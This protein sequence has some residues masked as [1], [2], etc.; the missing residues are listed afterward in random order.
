MQEQWQNW[1]KDQLL[2]EGALTGQE[3]VLWQMAEFEYD[4]RMERVNHS[5]KRFLLV[6]IQL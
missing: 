5:E 1:L 6:M 3:L 4:M 2:K